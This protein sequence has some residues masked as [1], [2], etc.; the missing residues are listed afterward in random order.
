MRKLHH[1]KRSHSFVTTRESIE[2]RMV[3]RRTLGHEGYEFFK[4]DD[5]AALVESV[6]E[7]N[8]SKNGLE[9]V[10]RSRE[11]LICASCALDAR[12]G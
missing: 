10:F 12:T 7:E 8:K 4:A 2:I 5:G 11:D 1:Q 3:V 6:M 9:A